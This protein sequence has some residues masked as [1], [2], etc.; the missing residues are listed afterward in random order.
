MTR[1]PAY[2]CGARL[3]LVGIEGGFRRRC[4]G[5]FEGA[6]APPCGQR[7]HGRAVEPLVLYRENEENNGPEK[8]SGFGAPRVGEGGGVYSEDACYATCARGV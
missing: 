3:F 1:F 4:G 7:R 6:D 2:L 5:V 8:E